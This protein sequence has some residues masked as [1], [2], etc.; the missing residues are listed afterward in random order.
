MACYS[1]SYKQHQVFF[2][3]N[4]GPYLTKDTGQMREYTIH[5]QDVLQVR[6]LQHRKY[7]VDEPVTVSSAKAEGGKD[8]GQTY[9]VENDGTVALP[10]LGHVQVGGLSR[11]EAALKIENLYRKELKD[12]IIELKIISLKVTLLGEINKQGIYNLM[13][14]KTSL[15]EM[16]GEGGGLNERA[17]IKNIKIVRG[18][19]DNPQVMEFDLSDVRTLSDPRT[20]LRHNDIIYITQNK[21]AV[22]SDKL[23]SMS[24]VLQPIVALLNTALIIY[25][26]T[27]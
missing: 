18:G 20:I 17:N 6:N 3:K 5:P 27:R 19:M 22:N 14:D 16:I 8:E 12:P 13:K 2:E 10:I 25:T 9:Q 26:I 15:I 7:I 1:C 21:R 11:H 23:K 4:S 24:A